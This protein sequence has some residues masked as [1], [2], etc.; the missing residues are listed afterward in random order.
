MDESTSTVARSG[1]GPNGTPASERAA[2]PESSAAASTGRNTIFAAPADDH[3]AR[4][5]VDIATLVVSVLVVV[6]AAWSHRVRGELD[7]RV[8][9][10]FEEGLPGWLS[11]PATIVFVLGGLY[12]LGLLVG[13]V[14][15]GGGRGA[16]ARDMVLAALSA[17]IGVI[18]LSYVAGP[19]FPDFLPEWLERS[20]Y[21]SY[22]VPRLALAVAL[23]RTAGPYLSVPMRKIGHRLVAAM[24]LSALIMTYGTVASVV[25]GFAVGAAAAAAIHLVFG[26]GQ[27]IPSRARISAALAD[28]GIEAAR[29]DFLPRQP[30]G[31]TLVRAEQSDG[32]PLLVKVYGRDAADAA[33]ATRLWRAIW[34]RERRHSLLASRSMLAAQEALVLLVCERSSI[35]TTR[36][37]GWSRAATDD[38]VLVAEWIDG[39]PFS[40]LSADELDDDVLD[41]AWATLGQLR[42]AGIAHG[43]IDSTRLFVT[44]DVVSIVG[45]AGAALLASD[46]ALL[47]DQAQLLV[48][49][50]LA[51]GNDRAIA[52]ARRNVGD[53]A[54]GACLSVLQTAAL[55]HS[56]QLEL[57]NEGRKVKTLR[58]EIARS[59]R[60]DEPPLVQLHRVSWGSVAM[61][62]LT[63]FAIYSL[64]TS[65]AGIGFDTIAQEMSD[66]MWAW[67]VVAFLTAQLTNVG[68]YLSLVGVVGSPVPFGPTM[69]FRYALSFIS[70]AVPSDAGAI[71]MNVRYQ[72]KLGVPPAA[73]IAQGPLLTLVS[74]GFDIIL[75]L[76]SVRFITQSVDFG[77]VDFGPIV[78]LVVVIGVIVVAAIGAV[79]AMPKLRARMLPHVK[80]GFVAVRDTVTDPNRLMRVVGGT[81]LQKVLFAM[82]LSASVAAFGS[83]LP[84]ASA[85]FVNS[86]VSLFVGLVPVPG[87]I[88]VGETA[89]TAGL[90]AVGISP[91]VAVAAAITHRMM[92]AYIPPVFGWWASRWLTA[93]D[94]L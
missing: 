31:A 38:I 56:L 29:I 43:E 78:K 87:G 94:Y 51:V 68:E 7:T 65:L 14:F 88:G 76:L 59:L 54:V 18:V 53:E 58:S 1:K 42:Q 50:A 34:Y 77:D 16:I 80:E 49:T 60:I 9:R 10:A 6:L 17:G 82:T 11:G 22:P 12:S 36:V 74:K 79:A 27:G 15:F 73:A 40:E 5:P 62:A 61:T 35:P 81:A 19:E 63:V 33:L 86:A 67:V 91:E 57:K 13:I 32:S 90:I 52:A 89:L 85:V 25:G 69:M 30:V 48:T 47:A 71:A 55:P 66:A 8:F 23:I 44:G 45:L 21:P 84:F 41:R 46:E 2:I 64:I 37:V 70:L 4:R 24:A 72:Q 92:T 20:G 83:S 39:T 28:A 3:R 75:L 26:S 93:R